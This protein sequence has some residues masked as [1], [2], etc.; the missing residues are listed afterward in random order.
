MVKMNN[1]ISGL[2]RILIALVSLLLVISIFVP[3]WRIE[4]WAP[5]YPE[6]LRLKIFSTKLNGDINIINGLNHYIGM[7]SLHAKDF[8]E[9]KVLPYIIGFYA[10]FALVAAFAGRKK[11]L[12]TLFTMFVLFGIV[13]MVDFW[14]W[15]YN[16]GH[17]LDPH[18]AIVVPGMAYQPPLLGYKKLLNF[19]AY[20][21][22]DKGGW[23]FISSG[24][25]L[26][27]A[28]LKE[29]SVIRRIRKNKKNNTAT[30]TTTATTTAIFLLV[31]FSS[32]KSSGPEPIKLNSDNCDYCK[33]S[34]A[35]M[36]FACELVTDKRRAYKFDDIKCM[37]DYKNENKDKTKNAVFYVCDYLEPNKL[38]KAEMLTYIRGEA[39][40]S[41]MGG[42]TAA[43]TNK[44]S[45][46]IYKNKFSAEV[47]PW[48]AINQ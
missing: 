24:V 6:G 28:V 1:R 2:S 44:D 10:L 27:A 20:S 15:E 11:I 41:P 42:N 17:D 43:Y 7:K 14:R 8:I 18:A 22:P 40:G 19:G 9:F 21:V 38:T 36:R 3:L 33:M 47:I 12:Y 46:L 5:Q 23:L 34:I 4:L 16:Y 25:L 39:I 45:A 31:L 29:T 37:A 26:L 30:V 48:S 35:D 13:A 32:C